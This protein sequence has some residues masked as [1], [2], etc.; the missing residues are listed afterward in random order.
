MA[1]D[2]ALG[3]GKRAAGEETASDAN[4]DAGD[5]AAACAARLQSNPA[6]LGKLWAT[7]AVDA[8][9]ARRFGLGVSSDGHYWTLPLSDAG[10]VVAVNPDISPI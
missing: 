3:R 7:R 1:P 5:L 6:A 8:G 4:F 10:H 9:T 2:G